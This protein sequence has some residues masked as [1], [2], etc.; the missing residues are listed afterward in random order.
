M[1]KNG[2]NFSVMNYIGRKDCNKLWILEIQ[3]V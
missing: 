3:K 2:Y 1:N